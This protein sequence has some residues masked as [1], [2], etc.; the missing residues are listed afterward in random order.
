MAFGIPWEA[1]YGGDGR[2]PCDKRGLG[3]PAKKVYVKE[4]TLNIS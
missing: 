2:G 4:K 1:G 3:T